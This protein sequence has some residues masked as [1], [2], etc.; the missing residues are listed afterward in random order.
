MAVSAKQAAK[1]LAKLSNFSL[2]NLELQKIL[3][4]ADMAHS[5]ANGKRLIS[6][7]FEAWDYGPVLPTVYH[8]CKTFGSKPVQNVFWGVR[9]IDGTEEAESLN[10]AYK[11]LKDMTPGQLVQN[12]HWP[13]GAWYKRY[14]P[15][16]RGV[17]ITTQDMIEEYER[18]IGKRN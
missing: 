11:V 4:I 6:E 10:E 1:H 2:S 5:G 7:N 14:S 9:D 3:Y 18:R 16:A 13:H 12:T 15:G 8:L 17:K